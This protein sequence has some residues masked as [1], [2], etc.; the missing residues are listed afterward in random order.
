MKKLLLLATGGT[1]ASKKMENGLSPQLSSEEILSYL[2]EE[3]RF[4]NIETRQILNIDSTNIQPED[5]TF[6]AEVI[7]KA[8]ED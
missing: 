2:P 6:I 7:Q 5:W 3:A 1:I 8:Y 4:A